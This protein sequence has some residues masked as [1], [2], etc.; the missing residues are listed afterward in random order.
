MSLLKLVQSPAWSVTHGGH[1][2]LKQ[3][4]HISVFFLYLFKLKSALAEDVLT[5][6]NTTV[7]IF[8]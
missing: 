6:V 8:K 4:Q 2:K 7:Y 5:N 1:F 3:P